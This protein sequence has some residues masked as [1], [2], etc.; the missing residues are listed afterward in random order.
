M[1]Q[2]DADADQS[3]IAQAL[4]AFISEAREQIES[5]EQLLLQLEEA[6][7]DRELLDSRVQRAF[8]VWTRWWRLPIT[9]KRCLII[10]AKAA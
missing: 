7:G 4:P 1:S 3:F 9:L 10:C 5:I 6:P 8:L 2:T